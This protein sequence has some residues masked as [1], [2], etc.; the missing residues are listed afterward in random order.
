MPE[1]R[2]ERG[3]G[4]TPQICGVD[5]DPDRFLL[6]A[7]DQG[8][9]DSALEDMARMQYPDANQGKV[10][11]RAGFLWPWCPRWFI[12]FAEPGD[13][14]IV[15]HVVRLRRFAKM[16]D[17]SAVRRGPLTS[18]GADLVDLCHYMA[19]RLDGDKRESETPKPQPGENEWQ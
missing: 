6:E 10:W 5:W 14:T 17:P 8:L 11:R 4:E 19:D 12:E 2:K 9:D 1:M 3:C 15:Q 7:M 13:V 18:G 16:G